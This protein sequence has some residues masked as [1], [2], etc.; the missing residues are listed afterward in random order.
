M[1]S[2][3]FNWSDLTT[4]DKLKESYKI[5]SNL[6]AYKNCSKHEM[7]QSKTHHL[8]QWG[9]PAPT[10]HEKQRGS[11]TLRNE[12]KILR[13]DWNST[14]W[15]VSEAEIEREIDR[16]WSASF[17][18]LFF[19]TEDDLR[20][21]MSQRDE[22]KVL[23]IGW[24]STLKR[25]SEPEIEREWQTW[26]CFFCVFSSSSQSRYRIERFENRDMGF[27]LTG[28][29]FGPAGC[30][31]IFHFDWLLYITKLTIFFRQYNFC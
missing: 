31:K 29:V 1:L 6:K 20:S 21:E 4:H 12:E 8:V 5:Y 9:T 26:I 27:L 25:V 22:E 19:F 15:R 2:N 3:Q 24:N 16:P 30:L 18:V 10:K 23:E 7:N 13:I 14:L 17:F 11:R 28:R